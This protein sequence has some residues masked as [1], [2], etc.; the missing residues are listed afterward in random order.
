MQSLFAIA[1]LAPTESSGSVGDTMRHTLRLLLGALGLVCAAL[2]SAR[3]SVTAVRVVVIPVK[4]EISDA[5]FYIIRHGLKKA[6]ES[7]ADFVV[8]DI[9]TPGGAL[10]STFQIM[11]A[12]EK[13][14]GHTIAYVDN[15]AMSAGAFVSAVTQE[16]WFAPDGVIGAAAPVQSTGQ[17]VDATMKQKLVSYLKARMRSVSEG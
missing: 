8:L 7:Q 16:I 1:A 14:P 17:D 10:D 9:K 11:E 15:E 12:L 3:A 2:G 6:I 4:G 5:Q 13:F